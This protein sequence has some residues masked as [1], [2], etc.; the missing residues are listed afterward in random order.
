MNAQ[1]YSAFFCVLTENG[2]FCAVYLNSIHHYIFESMNKRKI[3]IERVLRS[4]SEKIIW[5]LISTEGGLSKWMAD[6]VKETDG[7][8]L[9][10]WGREYGRTD[11]HDA[12]IVEVVKFHHLRLRWK[13]E[14][15]EQ[16]YIELCMEK[17]ELT[18][19]YILRVTDWALDDEME[20]LRGLWEQN[21][22]RLR[23]SSGL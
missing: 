16:A 6:E 12:V 11:S 15:D 18:G 13:D 21:F 23:R 3:Q 17:N 2:Y 20:T 9:F 14:D 4:T 1:N 5:G 10:T 19:D 8:F 7:G 22:E